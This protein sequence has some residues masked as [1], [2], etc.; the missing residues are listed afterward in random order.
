MDK[1]TTLL[2]LVCSR[3]GE[4]LPADRLQNLSPAG[5]PLLVQYDLQSAARTLR[6]DA[7]ADL[8]KHDVALLRSAARTLGRRDHQSR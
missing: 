8:Y 6:L 2:G 4:T 1:F 5:A 3:T 7:M